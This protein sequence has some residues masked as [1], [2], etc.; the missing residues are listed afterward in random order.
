MTH[1]QD[2]PE[3]RRAALSYLMAEVYDEAFLWS[4]GGGFT[5]PVADPMSSYTDAVVG[6]PFTSWAF[7][8]WCEAGFI[9]LYYSRQILRATD[10][11]RP[12]WLARVR[13]ARES[14]VLAAEDA[15]EVFADPARWSN[16]LAEG[17]LE[18]VRTDATDDLPF[19]DWLRALGPVD[20]APAIGADPLYAAN[21]QYCIETQSESQLDRWFSFPASPPP[22][23]D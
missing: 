8:R 4:T 3:L 18:V 2:S 13:I 12:A 1:G 10:A 5:S 20:D 9:E 14:V 6:W 21:R 15:R 22:P 16:W 11:D 7:S 23:P 19:E 17:R